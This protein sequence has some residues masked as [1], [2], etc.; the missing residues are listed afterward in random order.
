VGLRASRSILR[1]N[2]SRVCERIRQRRDLHPQHT[3]LATQILQIVAGVH[4]RS[5]RLAISG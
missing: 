2:G 3:D 5:A 1:S 4:S